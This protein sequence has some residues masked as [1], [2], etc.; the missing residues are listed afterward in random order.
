MGNYQSQ[1]EIKS[2]KISFTIFFT[3]FV[4]II[5]LDF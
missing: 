4:K 3:I 5:H 1:L 2:D